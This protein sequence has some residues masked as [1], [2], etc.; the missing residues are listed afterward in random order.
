MAIEDKTS[1]TVMFA[2]QGPATLPLFRENLEKFPIDVDAMGRYGFVTGSYMG[3]RARDHQ[4]GPHDPHPGVRRGADQ[5]GHEDRE[6]AP[7]GAAPRADARRGR[8]AGGHGA[9]PRAGDAEG[10]DRAALA[11]DAGRREGQFLDRGL[12]AFAEHADARR[13]DLEPDPARRDRLGP[14]STATTWVLAI[15]SIFGWEASCS[16]RYVDIL[17]TSDSPRTTTDTV[18][19]YRANS[20]AACPAEFA[21]PI[22]N[23]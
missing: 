13:R 20:M 4:P 7:A 22:T 9:R 5:Q 15:T 16:I 14:P 3:N 10:G 17:A 23:T 1:S 11:R 12:R 19:A 18:E 8:R 6:P 21:P 2:I